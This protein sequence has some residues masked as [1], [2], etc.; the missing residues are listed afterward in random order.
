M[1][2]ATRPGRVPALLLAAI[3]ALG[4]ALPGGGPAAQD[5]GHATIASVRLVELGQ[6]RWAVRVQATGPLAFD[7]VRSAAH[8][9]ATQL[10]VRL[11]R[12]RLAEDV[13][14]LEPPPFGR[15]RF[16]EERSGHVM[17]WLVVAA[18]FRARVQQGGS[19]NAV[20]VRIDPEAAARDSR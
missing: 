4:A 6:N 17:L 20:E 16:A 1:S 3:A 15:L 7:V 11:Y 8:T 12:A 2:T 5:L 10:D 14:D 13:G 9:G 18:G 19:P